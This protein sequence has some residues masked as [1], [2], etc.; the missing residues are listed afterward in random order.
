MIT[1][2]IVCLGIATFFFL[3]ISIFDMF[4]QG[5]DEA[6]SA[7]SVGVRLIATGVSLFIFSVGNGFK[8]FGL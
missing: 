1:A 7:R 6:W 2:I 8:L 4:V 5:I 3:C